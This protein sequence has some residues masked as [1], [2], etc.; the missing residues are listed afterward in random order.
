VDKRIL[1]A[2]GTVVVAVVLF[3]VLRPGA[4]DETAQT[5]SGQTISTAETTG[6]T[7]TTGEPAPP[8]PTR[9]ELTV[10]G[11][12]PVGGV[13]RI[14]LRQGDRVVVVVRSDVSD[15]VHVHG[16]DLMKE[17]TPGEPASIAFQA[18]LVGGFEIELESRHLLLAELQVQP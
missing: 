1:L 13:E 3:L 9:I 5:T 18:R 2:A 11:G 10:R 7:T 8:Q 17:V 4:S 6:T 14:D 12:R 15:E 16:Y